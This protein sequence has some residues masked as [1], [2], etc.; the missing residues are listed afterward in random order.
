MGKSSTGHEV[1]VVVMQV[2]ESPG[3]AL[4]TH[5]LLWQHGRG[6]ATGRWA[7]P[8]GEVRRDENLPT[9]AL[10]QLAEKV[11][12][13][14]VSHLEEVAV[15]SEPRRVPARRVIASGFVALLP[16]G[17]EPSLPGDTRW[18][19]ASDLPE[20]AFDHSE[21]VE[22]SLG[23]VAA[24]LSYS[25]LGFALAPQEFTMS[26]LAAVYEAALGH[27]VDPTNLRRVLSRRSELEA[28]GKS[29][30]SGPSGGRPA[31]IYRFAEHRLR[32]TDQFAALRP[33]GSA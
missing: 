16:L 6:P 21:I 24:K 18:W 19:P 5:V 12:V 25:N 9:S 2:R 22:R 33:P 15:F 8:G 11:D 17:A 28:C 27:P 32:I 10:R 26:T 20:L 3:G 30:A 31:S 4:A 13:R 29:T 1:R 7:L 23:R 14:N